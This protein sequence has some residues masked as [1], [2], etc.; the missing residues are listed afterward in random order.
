MVLRGTN[1]NIIGV[2]GSGAVALATAGASGGFH[3]SIL[4][5]NP[6]F[7]YT[8]PPPVTITSIVITILI[9]VGGTGYFAVDEDP[10]STKDSHATY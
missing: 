4:I 8:G 1:A 2:G 10:E 7:G 5:I 6:G 9:L 3:H